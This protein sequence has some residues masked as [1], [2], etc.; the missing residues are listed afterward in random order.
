MITLN[1]DLAYSLKGID[2]KYLRHYIKSKSFFL[3]TKRFFDIIVSLIVII[4]FLSWF[5]PIMA[6]AIK[7]TS[8]GPVFFIQRRVGRGLKSFRCIKFRTMVI[9]DEP[10]QSAAT[11]NDKR[12]TPLGRFLRKTSIDE[13]PQ[14]FN[15]LIGDMSVVGPRPHMFADCKRFSTYIQYYKFRT[16]VRP[17]ITGLAQ[18][19]GFR[20]PAHDLH[21][22]AS[23]F[24][25][26]SLYIKHMSFFLDSRIVLSTMIQSF[27]T[28]VFSGKASKRVFR[29]IRADRKKIAA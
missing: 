13:L 29:K 12:V 1:H 2:K 19:N 28:I 11:G 3:F 15:V 16:L 5:A 10:D 7:L 4:F 22:I 8:S 17:G 20:G 18:V 23:R 14:F 21:H 27:N 24:S 25:Y 6:I 26:D 9:N